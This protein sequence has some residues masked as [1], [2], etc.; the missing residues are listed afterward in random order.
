M[1]MMTVYVWLWTILDNA[2]TKKR[3]MTDENFAKAVSMYKSAIKEGMGH[4]RK[5]LSP[6]VLVQA[7]IPERT[8]TQWTLR[9]H[10]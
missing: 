5:H 1:W 6:C 3:L 4:S 9:S 7:M 10:V 2:E 8:P